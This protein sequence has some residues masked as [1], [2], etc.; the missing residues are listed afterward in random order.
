VENYKRAQVSSFLN[1]GM[2]YS[3]N[4]LNSDL[5]DDTPGIKGLKGKMMILLKLLDFMNKD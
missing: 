1:N 5:Y 4:L 2:S 3:M